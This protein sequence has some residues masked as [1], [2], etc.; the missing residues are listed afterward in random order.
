MKTFLGCFLLVVSSNA[1]GQA[2]SA[3]QKT[4]NA[5]SAY[6]NRAGEEVSDVVETAFKQY[7]VLAGKYPERTRYTCPFQI[8]E[9]FVNTISSQPKS[10]VL[11][12]QI[13]NAFLNLR[14]A[15]KKVDEKCKVLDTYYKLE[16]YKRDNYQ[17]A[18][19]L[20]ADLQPL[21]VDFRKKYSDLQ[22]SLEDAYKKASGNAP[23]TAYSSTSVLLHTLVENE[24][25]F[26][27]AWRLNF[28]Q[29]AYS[30]WSAE[31]LEASI[32]ASAQALEKLKSQKPAL[33]YPASSMWEH[34]K[35][36]YADYIDVKRHAL[37]EH[38]YEATKSDKHNNDVYL[39]LI[40]HFN[41]TLVADYNTFL[42][43]SERDGFYGLSTF[44]YVPGFE[45]INEQ[46][47]VN[48]EIKPFAEVAFEPIKTAPQKTIIT[49][50]VFAA[51]SEY[52]DFINE[53]YHQTHSLQST[54]TSFNSSASYFKT[55]ASYEKRQPM[56]LDYSKFQVPHSYFQKVISASK[57]LAPSIAK[58]LNAQ[59]ETIMNVLKEMDNL[60]A[61]L[62]MEVKERRYEKDR[63]ER[64]YQILEREAVLMKAWDDKK[65]K[66]YNDV[67]A[68][69]ESF[70]PAN[71]ESSW[72]KSGKAL[73]DLVDLDHDAVFEARK[74]YNG[75]STVK[76][77]TEKIE[78]TLRDVLAKE[79]DNLQG[80]QKLGR[81]NG[82]CPYSPYEDVPTTSRQLVEHF[83]KLAPR[84]PSNSRY[85]DPYYSI[86]YLYNDVVD[87]YNKFCELST[88]AP[89]LKTV[90]QP[91][92]FNVK[93]PDPT[94]EKNRTRLTDGQDSNEPLR[95]ASATEPN[96]TPTQGNTTTTR[97]S[98]SS[99]HTR[100]T[101]YIEK[102]DTIYIREANTELRSMEGYATN[103][104]VL[105]LDISGS[106]NQP[107]KLPL[108]KESMLR[109]L[110][111]MRLEDQV[112]IIGFSGKPKVLLKP[113]SFKEVEK[114]KKAV[115]DLTSSGKTDG[116]AA[117]KMAYKVADE[118][119]IRGGNN[120]IILATDGEF[121][122][123]EETEK[124]IEQFSQNDI[125]LTV[126]NFGKGVG[127]SK[128]LENLA[129]L[130]KGN[131][132]AISRENVDVKLINE[133]K[134]KR[135]R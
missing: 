69:Y 47:Q 93:Y 59:A 131:F 94:S 60:G 50:P 99:S 71:M 8:E 79:F 52:I 120:R 23:T 15:E 27:D 102:R 88:T 10:P 11:S 105:L 80:I 54:L 43:F 21:V 61:S 31:K 22:R 64:V 118:N 84:K 117:I 51:L 1:L 115:S 48:V 5:Y 85:N 19:Q 17:Q 30:G 98:A 73:R 96:T 55:L 29:A 121:A 18:R 81:Y 2:T 92:A 42:Q 26:L 46:T 95:P 53:T 25:T 4:L 101:I 129:N 89:H 78:S 45:I 36:V 39:N 135:K 107:E 68:I 20:I 72:Q 87:D 32:A 37:D 104:M 125:F 12:S 110:D 3:A 86:I 70:L 124:L 34:F 44:K 91:E 111:M 130:G 109:M 106:M 40:N 33:K 24:R 133:A 13:N 123:D 65:E 76:I 122:M 49:K 28:H 16:D 63:L 112:S 127:A 126:F 7:D 14:S 9:Y 132:E 103:N 75:D 38:N 67:R 62:D 77:N 128:T 82:N 35:E 119:Y 100:D 74:F 116:R 108:L 90:F 83:Q 6:A 114:I 41:G 113:T 58:S 57:A 97:S 134:A 56:Y 66:L